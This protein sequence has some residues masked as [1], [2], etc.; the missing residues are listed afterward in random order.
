MSGTTLTSAP[1]RERVQP[2]SPGEV[3]P[4]IRYFSA[5]GRAVEIIGGGTK[6]QLGAP[7]SA[8]GVL[9][10]SKLVGVD[11]YEP[12][13][14]VI[15]VQAGL[16]VSQLRTLLAAKNQQLPFDPPDY[17]AV[18]GIAGGGTIGGIVATNLAG[19]ARLSG[20]APRDALLGFEGV[21]GRGEPFKAGGR[22]VKNV[23]G[24][25]LSKLVAGSYGTLAAIT[26]V[27]LKVTPCPASETTLIL[28]G[29]DARQAIGLLIDALAT[30]AGVT[31][32]AHLPVPLASTPMTALRLEG[33]PKSV[34]DRMASLE[35]LLHRSADV[36]RMEGEQSAAF[37]AGVRDLSVMIIRPDECLWR[38]LGPATQA[39][40]TVGM[41]GGRA[42]YD[43][44]GSQVFLATPLSSIEADATA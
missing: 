6:L 15:R 31:C 30:S 25:D 32:A 3:A 18:L 5:D 4:A 41:V 22:T 2:A 39:A 23:T 20:G 33:P 16:P 19:P 28:S 12:E 38:L 7:V 24:F 44:G 9:D 42:L 43:W 36:S 11:F 29:P 21:N 27:T 14:L 40:R 8:P 13:E 37:W 17:A 10:L 26:S 34:A 1:A 35:A